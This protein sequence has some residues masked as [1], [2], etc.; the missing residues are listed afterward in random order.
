[1][2][3]SLLFLFLA[4]VPLM[5]EED[6]YT[7]TLSYRFRA[8]QGLNDSYRPIRRDCEPLPYL[9]SPSYRRTWD[10]P[11]WYP[12]LPLLRDYRALRDYRELQYPLYPRRRNERQR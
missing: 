1:M 12:G 6:P 7:Q 4:S 3:L 8:I 5:A 10:R 11:D 9:Y 2:R